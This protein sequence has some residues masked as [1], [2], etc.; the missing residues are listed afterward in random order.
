MDDNVYKSALS[1]L[2]SGTSFSDLPSDQQAAVRT[3]KSESSERGNRTREAL[4]GEDTSK[5][6]FLGF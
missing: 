5:R 1:N 3:M 6:N 2:Q 4:R